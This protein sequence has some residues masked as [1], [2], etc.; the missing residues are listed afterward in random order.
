MGTVTR[1]AGRGG[2]ACAFGFLHE[3]GFDG[4]GGAGWDVEFDVGGGAGPLVH[5][6]DEGVGVFG[7]F[8]G[9]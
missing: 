7:F 1:S 2:G 5:A 6:E 4:V 3:V 9:G 8:D